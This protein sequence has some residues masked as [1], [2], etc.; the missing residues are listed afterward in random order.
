MKGTPDDVRWSKKTKP[1]WP[2]RSNRPERGRKGESFH[3]LAAKT[4]VGKITGRVR[5]SKGK[6]G[7]KESR[8]TGEGLDLVP[9]E[10]N[11]EPQNETTRVEQ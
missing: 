4:F 3:D 8:G 10:K 7:Q 2:I 6:K 1:N 11:W 5:G 9:Q